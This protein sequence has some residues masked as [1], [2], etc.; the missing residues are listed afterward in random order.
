MSAS[1]GPVTV[2]G[3]GNVLLRDDGVGVHV[4][5]ELE[6]LARRGEIVLPPGTRLV[7]GGTRG[8]DLLPQIAAAGAVLFVDAADSGSAPG[9]VAAIPADA[10]RRTR[11]GSV[12]PRAGVAGLLATARLAGVLPP[13]V[14]LVGVQPESIEAGL[15][16]SNV[17]GAAIPAAVEAAL[18]EV[19]RLATAMAR[20][21]FVAGGQELAGVPA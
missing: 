2:I 9:A 1:R 8:L 4:V 14:A 15:E 18:A 19:R 16:L 20:P 10:L 11:P 5:R 13:G 6:R 12:G 17:V 3:V 7:D 21:A